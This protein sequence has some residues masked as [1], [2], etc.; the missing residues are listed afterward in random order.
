MLPLVMGSDEGLMLEARGSLE[1]Y[2]D[3]QAPFGIQY[4]VLQTE[5]RTPLLSASIHHLL[6]SIPFPWPGFVLELG[7]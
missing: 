2:I 7:L 4:E 1:K 3:S 5:M 6:N